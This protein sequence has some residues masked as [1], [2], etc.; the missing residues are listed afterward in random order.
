MIASMASVMVRR[1]VFTTD[2]VL[3]RLIGLTGAFFERRL[4][5]VLDRRPGMAAVLWNLN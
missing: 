2:L 5:R 3:L 1:R 4:R